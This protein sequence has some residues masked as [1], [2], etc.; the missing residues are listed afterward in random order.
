MT[1]HAIEQRDWRDDARRRILW[2]DETGEVSGDHGDLPELR[3]WLADAA[4]KGAIVLEE[5][6]LDVPD[7]A[8]VPAQFLAVLRLTMGNLSWD[9][10]GLPPDL[11]AVEPVR[12]REPPPGVIT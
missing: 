6:R 10:D 1:V 2:N 7:A 11:R 8:R 3:S 9:P 12:W 4:K 5:G